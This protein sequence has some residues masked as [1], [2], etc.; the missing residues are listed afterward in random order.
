MT[1]ADRRYDDDVSMGPRSNVM[2]K[3]I[4]LACAIVWVFQVIAGSEARGWLKYYLALSRSGV[5]RGCLWQPAT[6]LFLHDTAGPLHILFNMLMLWWWGQSVEGALGPRRFAWLY[7]GSGLAAA[8]L[9]C[10][11]R[12]NAYV[13]G[14]SGAVNG[15]MVAFAVLFPDV[16][17]LF[18]FIFPMK[19]KHLA[20]LLIGLSLLLSVSSSGDVAHTAHLGGAIFGLIFLKWRPATKAASQARSTRHLRSQLEQ[21]QRERERVDELLD[22]IRRSGMAS[23]TKRERQ[24]LLKASEHYR[25]KSPH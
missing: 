8:A 20:M 21:Q 22:K 23:L 4:V 5:L 9:F 17:V 10:L 3:G 11:V 12:S 15:V 19:A 7:L 25:D 6:Y 14:A 2:V 24:F 16:Q 1:W 13:L 18:M